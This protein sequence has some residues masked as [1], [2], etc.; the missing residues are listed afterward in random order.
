MNNKRIR[1]KYFPFSFYR[2]G[3]FDTD[4]EHWINAIG[5][6]DNFTTNIVPVRDGVLVV[7]ESVE[8]DPRWSDDV[9]ESQ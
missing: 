8:K 2:D 7:L 1:C 6:P 4:I 5:D 3:F 9:D